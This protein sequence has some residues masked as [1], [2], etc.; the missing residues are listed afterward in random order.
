MEMDT[1]AR[2]R[3]MMLLREFNADADPD[4]ALQ[5]MAFRLASLEIEFGQISL[6]QC[7]CDGAFGETE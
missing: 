3:A 2:N 6:E 1:L 7:L 5:E 4:G